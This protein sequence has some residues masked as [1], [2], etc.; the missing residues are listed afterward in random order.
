MEFVKSMTFYFQRNCLKWVKE[1]AH[2]K[3]TPPGEGPGRVFDPK[4]QSRVRVTRLKMARIFGPSF[5]LG[6]NFNYEIWA[7]LIWPK[8]RPGSPG[9][10]G[11]FCCVPKENGSMTQLN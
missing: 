7:E 6:Q 4:N 5:I 1:K 8:K 9:K 3:M 10:E 11:S 2:N